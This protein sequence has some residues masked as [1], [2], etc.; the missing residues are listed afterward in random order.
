MERGLLSLLAE[1]VEELVHHKAPQLSSKC[2]DECSDAGDQ[3]ESL[4][5]GAAL[6]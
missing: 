1:S 3:E 5:V 6:K 4:V 2:E